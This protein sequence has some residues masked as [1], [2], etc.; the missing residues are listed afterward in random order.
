[1]FKALVTEVSE[2]KQLPQQMYQY[3]IYN[4]EVSYCLYDESLNYLCPMV[5]AANQQQSKT[6]TFKD[7]M[8]QL[9][10]KEFIMAML[11][12]FKVHEGRK[13]WT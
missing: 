13:H 11:K 10:H 7:M 3:A 8:K 5:F 6:Y 9:D 2:M 1:M 12:E 4:I